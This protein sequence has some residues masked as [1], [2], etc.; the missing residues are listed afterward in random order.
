MKIRTKIT[1]MGLFLV[2]LTTT[3][4]LGI[5]VLLKHSL[6]EDI[7]SAIRRQGLNAA[8]M[9]TQSVYLMAKTMQESM[10]LAQHHHLQV[11]REVLFQ[12][13]AVALA[14][15]QVSWLASNQY[16]QKT[17]AITLPALTIGNVWPGQNR[18]SDTP[19]P[20]VDRVR[21][22]VGGTCTIFQRMNPQGDML[23][24]ATNVE[25]DDGSRATGTY[26][27]AI[28]PD[29]TPNP[30]IDT[31]LRGETFYGRAYVVNDWYV[32]AYEPILDVA[33][34]IIGA[35]YVGEK[36]QNYSLLRQSIMD[37]R[38]GKSGYVYIL[39]GRGEQRGN[40]LLSP[41]GQRDGANIL[42]ETDSEGRPFIKNI[43]DRAMALSFRNAAQV[44]TFTEQYS[45]RNPGDRRLRTKTVVATYFEPWDWVIAAGFYEDDFAEFY[46]LFNTALA[47]KSEDLVAT[48]VLIAL[49]ALTLGILVARGIS[50]PLEQAI[51]VFHQVGRG[52]LDLSMNIGGSLDIR[53]LSR[54]FNHMVESLRMVTANR[55]ELNR[56]IAERRQAEDHLRGA[57]Q[58]METLFTA[59]PLAITVLDT[60]G[61]I[62]RWNPAAEQMFGWS[63]AEVTGHPCPLTPP[64]KEAIYLQ[65]FSR[66]LQGRA[67]L[68]V[69]MLRRR[70]DG[71][72]IALK[73]SAAPL[74]ANDQEPTGVITIFDDITRRKQMERELKESEARFRSIFEN[75][76][77]G[78]VTVN[79]EGRFL[80][81]NKGFCDMLGYSHEEMQQMSVDQVTH[82]DHRRETLDNYRIKRPEKI[83][84]DKRYLRRDGS[85][86]WAHVSAT[87]VYDPNQEPR[88]AIAMVRDITE[89]KMAEAKQQRENQVKEVIALILAVSLEPI[90]LEAKLQRALRKIL[91][92][93]GFS[94]LGQGCLF[95]FDESRE[96]LL[97]ASQIGLPP[98][99]QQMCATVVPG[100][101]LCGRASSSRQI[102][103]ADAGHDQHDFTCEGMEPHGHLCA[104]IYSGNKLLGVLNIYL[105][106]GHSQNKDA[107][108]YIESVTR[109]LAG[110]IER[111]NYEESLRQARDLAE[112]ANRAK[113]EFLANMSHEIRTPMNGIIGMTEL[114]LDHP[115]ADEQR[116]CLTLA[117]ES[118]LALLRLLNDI[119]DFSKIE[120][121]KLILESVN[122]DLRQVLQSPLTAFEIQAREK[123]LRLHTHFAPETPP[124]LYGDPVRLKQVVV[125]LV[126]NAVKFTETG[127]IDVHIGPEDPDTSCPDQGFGLHIAVS[128]TGIGI[129]GDRLEHIFGSFSQLDGSVTRRYGGTGLGLAICRELVTLMG[130]RI[131]A[132][133]VVD[134]G[135]T[136]HCRI[137]LT[138]AE[139]QPVENKTSI[140][141][142]PATSARP[143]RILLAED[144]FVNQRLVVKIL[145]KAGHRVRVANNGAEAL[146]FL[147]Q[148]PYDLVLM[149][150]QMP[151]VDGLE[152]TR[153]IRGGTRAGIDPNIA[154]IAL[155]AHAMKGDAQRFF[156]AGMNGY[157]S[158][159]IDRRQLLAAI[160]Q[161]N[162][163]PP[164]PAAPASSIPPA[165]DMSELL[166]R[167]DGDRQLVRE[168]WQVFAEDTPRQMQKLITALGEGNLAQA[169]HLAHSLK[170]AAANIGAIRL[171]Q[172]AGRLERTV[173][174]SGTS[175]EKDLI[176]E[177][178]REFERVCQ[179]LAE[180]VNLQN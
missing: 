157:V 135:S 60:D 162:P 9:A 177:V 128:D 7:D 24:V 19:T 171:Q 81:L 58:Q 119:L 144:N 155:T 159:P 152:A 18:S 74:F 34:E 40:Y 90:P 150:V 63:E 54:A 95:L 174:D 138:I 124:R 178:S 66:I 172:G 76:A 109:T 105:P 1:S 48:T 116:E 107:Q 78:M 91:S 115:L 35:L 136:F 92:I 110:L 132:E 161:T 151:E 142:P 147:G 10:V 148:S 20:V 131:W 61:R 170:G 89:R 62:V 100:R 130:G 59:A 156:D 163:A 133:S 13:G 103:Y 106:I 82:P 180:H 126:G 97:M 173:R 112:A 167:L 6:S 104:P 102:L 94:F 3:A 77:A 29:G 146:N 28:N 17:S 36:L 49:I 114:V 75:T 38:I 32:T 86:F 123:G 69:E 84:Y 4:F 87:W 51:A 39:G 56:E 153:I 149:D 8:Q 139:E 27:P 65:N 179:Y 31:L 83:S 55:D 47:K 15:R 96:L 154:I 117:H 127:A 121:G 73:F 166:E 22:L 71:T 53:Q 46:D 42:D 41:K 16:T 125:N 12:A 108:F 45:W 165:I 113:S 64:G 85:D 14:D 30:V 67:M 2:L 118:A 93:S 169:E 80:Q 57:Q 145:E 98:A 21:D 143:L 5:S 79:P 50:R 37:I 23:R 70:R 122:F 176:D 11:A 175:P 164:G 25:R 158:K 140:A 52:N 160:T 120:A 101:C 137:P 26:I 33:G 111:H 129:P 68:G 141:A 88:Y 44:P 43:I 72:P 99:V 168:I 134:L